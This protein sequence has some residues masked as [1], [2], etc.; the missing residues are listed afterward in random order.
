M[1]CIT[2][3]VLLG[4]G[5]RT[6]MPKTEADPEY[7]N[8]FGIRWDG[9]NLIEVMYLVKNVELCLMR[10][11]LLVYKAITSYILISLFRNGRN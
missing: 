5:R 8:K 11:T 9:R 7:P 2:I 6:F 3:Q 1:L 4:G 10:K